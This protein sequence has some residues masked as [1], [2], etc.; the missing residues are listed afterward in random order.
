MAKH[1][2]ILWAQSSADV[3]LTIEADMNVEEMTVDGD[4]FKFRGKKDSVEYNADLQFF[5][6]LKG[7]SLLLE[8]S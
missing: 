8:F 1:P 6:K 3:Y 7:R 5:G 4:L 2:T